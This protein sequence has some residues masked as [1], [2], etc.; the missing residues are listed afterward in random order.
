[1]RR[2]PVAILAVAGLAMTACSSGSDKKN[3]SSHSAAGVSTS[4]GADLTGAGATF[5]YPLY[6]RWVSEYAAATGV[7]IN[8]QQIGSGGG[9]KQLQEQTVDFGASDAPM[10]DSEMVKAKG[11]AVFHI[12]SVVGLVAIAYNLPQ[13]TQPLKLSG[14]IVADIFLG[15]ITKWN[16]SRIAALNPGVTLPNSDILVVHRSE[17][18]GTTYVFSDYLS[19]VSPTWKA[20][21]GKGKELQWPVGLGERGNDG[22]AGRIKQTPGAVGYVE[23]AF[24]KQNRLSSA[25]LQ[26]PSGQFVAP[27]DEAATAAA[28]AAIAKLPAN[29]DYRISIVNSPGAG[30]Y[31]I[32][33]LTY[34]LVYQHMTDAAKAKKLSDFI[35]W[36]LTTGQKDASSLDYAPLPPSMIAK[37]TARADSVATGSA[38]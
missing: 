14:P 13:V 24:V 15:K 30:A 36:A 38:R 10:S 26:N 33:S 21:P 20:G 1:M 19:A 11:G 29:S 8:Y 35:K 17:G 12:P 3:D 23:M 4:G 25:L 18:S 28:D 6:S 31:P 32:S 2:T 16:D 27:S 9:I 5:P 22:V 7:K 37:L 34:L